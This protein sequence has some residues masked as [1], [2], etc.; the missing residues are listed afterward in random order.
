MAKFASG[1]KFLSID[2]CP[3]GA[4]VNTQAND[5]ASALFEASKN[6]HSEVVEILLSYRA[7]VNKSNKAGLFPIHLAAK[8]GHCRFLKQ[9][10]SFC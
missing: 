6:G 4:D 2:Y 9:C 5:G 7:D 10:L 8:N 3:S 1:H